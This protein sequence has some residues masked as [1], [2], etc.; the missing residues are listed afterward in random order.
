LGERSLALT[1]GKFGGD[2]FARKG[3]D[4]VMARR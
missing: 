2:R 1:G 4:S 3:A